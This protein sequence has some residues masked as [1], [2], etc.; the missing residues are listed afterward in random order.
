MIDA[1]DQSVGQPKLVN[2]FL[3]LMI[4]ETQIFVRGRDTLSMS[5]QK[6]RSGST[7]TVF[8]EEKYLKYL[9]DDHYSQV[10]GSMFNVAASSLQHCQ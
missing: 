7:T 10:Q 2:S 5:T 1:C 4:W 3:H 8:K 9:L 6:G